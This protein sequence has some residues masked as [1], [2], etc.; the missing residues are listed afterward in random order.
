MHVKTGGARKGALQAMLLLMLLPLGTV[1]VADA[2][3]EFGVLDEDEDGRISRAELRSF[4]RLRQL[5]DAADEDGNGSLSVDE[6]RKLT[7][8]PGGHGLPE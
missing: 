2:K 8:L 7:K 3:G 4:P 6:Y 5:F 1:A